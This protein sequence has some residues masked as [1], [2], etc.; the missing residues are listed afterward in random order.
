[1]EGEREK[2]TN[3]VSSSLSAPAVN[4]DI[5]LKLILGTRRGHKTGVGRTL[6]QR[7]HS[8][9]PS[10][11]SRSEGSTVRVD[12][13]VEEYLH[14]SYEQNLQIYE[15]QRIMQELLTRL[16]PNIQFPVIT[17]SE[18]FVPPSPQPLLDDGEDAASNAAN[19]GD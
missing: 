7:T 18:L 6:S 15:S 3:I 14:Q 16:H 13:V 9:A 17:R 8:G 5:I 10:S 2:M 19:L 4:E 12:L 1:M 11:I